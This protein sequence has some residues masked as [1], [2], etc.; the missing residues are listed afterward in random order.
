MPVRNATAI[1]HGNLFEGK[2]DMKFGS[3]AFEG[4]YSFKSRFEEGTGTNPEELIG[5]AHAG[6][7]SMAFS[8]TLADNGFKPET[9]QTEARVHLNK[10]EGGFSITTIELNTE[11]RIPDIDDE[12]FQNLAEDAKK[13]CPV[14]RALAGVEIRLQAKLV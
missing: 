3:G 13:N 7:F 11:A 6:C 12:K 9:V 10:V 14:S 4:Q 8:A 2:G 5:A 1:W